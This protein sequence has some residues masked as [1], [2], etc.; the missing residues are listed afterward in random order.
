MD[1]SLML[2]EQREGYLAR[3]VEQLRQRHARRR[4]DEQPSQKNTRHA[5]IGVYLVPQPFT[6]LNYGNDICP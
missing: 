4:G 5:D 2:C 3:A 1:A 6:N